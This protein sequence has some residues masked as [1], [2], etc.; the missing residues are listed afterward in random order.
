MF[1]NMLKPEPP[2]HVELF[3]EDK[4]PAKPVIKKKK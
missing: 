4:T 2:K 1:K 3:K